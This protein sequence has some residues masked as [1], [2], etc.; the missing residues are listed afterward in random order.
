MCQISGADSMTGRRS[1]PGDNAS[2]CEHAHDASGAAHTCNPDSS[3][4]SSCAASWLQ[5]LAQARFQFRELAALAVEAVPQQLAAEVAVLA[6]QPLAVAEV[7]PA[8]DPAQDRTDHL[9]GL[10]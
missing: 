6:Q 5:Q 8:A 9:T 4:S 10:C 3:A 1:K 7:E 2:S